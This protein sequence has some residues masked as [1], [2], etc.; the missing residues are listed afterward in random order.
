MI[1][2]QICSSSFNSND[3]VMQKF[4]SVNKLLLA[5]RLEKSKNLEA[6]IFNHSVYRNLRPICVFSLQILGERYDLWSRKLLQSFEADI[7]FEARHKNL[8]S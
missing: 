7:A 2:I 8:N 1:S 4:F 3:V 5:L 6:D